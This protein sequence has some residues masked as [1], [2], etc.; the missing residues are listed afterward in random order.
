MEASA[1]G[2]YAIAVVALLLFTRT[3]FRHSEAWPSVL[4]ALCTVALI[5]GLA[6]LFA[7]GS[8]DGGGPDDL[9]YWL[10]FLGYSVACAWVAGE[11]GM[12]TASARKR[13]RI[14]L[15]DPIVANRFLLWFGFGSLQLLSCL[16][17]FF[18]DSDE[19]AG[20]AMSRSL[21]ALLGVTELA[22]IGVVWLAFFAPP[23]YRRWVSGSSE[24][25][26]A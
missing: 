18:A 22:S 16:I 11:A 17:L 10:Y 14:G 1:L 15:C 13:H 6:G 25:T 23:A 21:D 4:I 2:M 3:V 7:A 19:A 24:P 20:D 5:S 8:W 9:A 26:P 12:A